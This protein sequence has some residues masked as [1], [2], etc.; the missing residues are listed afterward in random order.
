V[1]QAAAQAALNNYDA[2][3]T[4]QQ[5][6]LAAA[7]SNA[8]NQ[9]SIDAANAPSSSGSAPSSGSGYVEDPTLATNAA[10]FNAAN[11]VVLPPDW[12]ANGIVPTMAAGTG[13]TGA[14]DAFALGVGGALSSS[15]PNAA[16]TVG[17]AVGTGVAAAAASAANIQSVTDSATDTLLSSIGLGASANALATIKLLTSISTTAGTN[18]LATDKTLTAVKTSANTDALAT[19]KLLTTIGTSTS[20]SAVSAATHTTL[21]THVAG[22]LDTHTTLLGQMKTLLASLASMSNSLSTI[23]TE[24]RSGQAPLRTA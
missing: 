15:A 24:L 1:A 8:Q 14:S 21:L 12:A 23:T 19:D 18:P 4:I 17:S 22:S 13:S 20:A 7:L 5:A 3:Q 2:L 11:N 6:T 9:T 10:A 16:P